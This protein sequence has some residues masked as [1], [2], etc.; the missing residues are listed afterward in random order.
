M[1]SL[2]V[3]QKTI[4]LMLLCLPHMLSVG[5]CK[6]YAY[7]YGVFSGK[8]MVVETGHLFLLGNWLMVT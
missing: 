1:V 8:C 3:D 4:T 5:V 7:Y 6:S 2:A